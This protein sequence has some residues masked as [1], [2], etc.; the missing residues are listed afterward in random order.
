MKKL[1]ALVL[2]LTMSLSLAACG[3]KTEASAVSASASTP[4]ASTSN[5]EATKPIV[6]SLS[7]AYSDMDQVNFELKAAAQRISERSNGAIDLKVYPNNTLGTPADAV[8]AIRSD[9]P[10]LYVTAF[11]QWEDYYPDACAIQ[12]GFV[13][14]SAEECV[15][16]YDTDLFDEIVANLDAVNIHCINVSFTAGMRHVLGKKPIKTPDDMKGLKLRV[17]GSS[18][19][20]DC[21]NSLGASPMAMPSSEQV[22]ALSAGT[23]DA[24]DQSISL[25]Y[26]T[27]TYELVKEATLLAQMPLA[28]GLYC[29]TTFWNSL[30][31]EYRNIIEEELHTAGQNYYEYSMENEAIMRIDMEKAGV[32]FYEVDR[33]PFAALAKENVLKYEIG[34]KVLDTVAQIRAD[35]AAGK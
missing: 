5:K 21:F 24:V 3:S 34:Q 32:R 4:E 29:S 18:P 2:A 16:F 8:E 13:F 1:F 19:Y 12:A 22:S 25:M 10:L 6:I 9:A 20:L 27:K 14:D 26:S 28:D 11:S 23:I 7:N 31:E 33:A 30:P 17:P 15:R 35:I